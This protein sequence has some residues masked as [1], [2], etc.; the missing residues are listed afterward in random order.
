M[1]T[2][3]PAVE[4]Q[5]DFW[6]P[7]D[8]VA[9]GHHQPRGDD[10][11]RA[12]ER[13]A[14]HE[15]HRGASRP[16]RRH[17]GSRR[18]RVGPDASQRIPADA[19]ARDAP[20]DDVDRADQREADPLVRLPTERGHDQPEETRVARGLGRE[21]P[22]AL[23]A[24]QAPRVREHDG[25]AL[26]AQVA[27][28][29]RAEAA[30]EE[31]HA[32]GAEGRAARHD[33]EALAERRAAPPGYG[34]PC[35]V[36]TAGCTHA[37][38]QDREPAEGQS[39]SRQLLVPLVGVETPLVRLLENCPESACELRAADQHQQ[40]GRDL[41]VSRRLAPGGW[42]RISLGGE[43]DADL[44]CVAEAV[45]QQEAAV[46]GEGPFVGGEP[47]ERDARADHCSGVTVDDD[48][49]AARGILR[50]K[51]VE[52]LDDAAPLLYPPN[53]HACEL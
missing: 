34:G 14:L 38:L 30:A 49:A 28:D 3:V 50:G 23:R 6:P 37:R 29:A 21:Q 42:G 45:R 33:R 53:L 15:A 5:A 48:P 46:R 2:P 18:S 52:H 51:C 9:A 44:K 10:D 8:D 32:E 22:A 31:V 1:L 43:A 27:E 16:A 36:G 4:L 17:E 24:G 35:G 19:A 13:P 20:E 39:V 40:L 11:P 12:P 7:V 47:G 41:P 26:P 25:V